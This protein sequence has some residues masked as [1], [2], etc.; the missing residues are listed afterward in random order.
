P[1]GG[2]RHPEQ[3][4]IQI[5][6]TQILFICGGTFTE[7]ADI[8]KRRIGQRAIGFS[9]ETRPPQDPH[10]LAELLEQTTPEDVIE[11]GIIPEFVGRL[12][13][14]TTLAPLDV[15]ALIRIMTEPRNALVRQYQKF[16]EMEGCKLEFQPPAL[17]L[18]AEKALQRNTGARALR[19]I[20]EELM[21]DYMFQLP[22]VGRRTRYVV[23]EAVVQG[24]EDLLRRGRP[25]KESA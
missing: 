14:I 25:L 12:P 23:T 13:I 21:L 6:T 1:Q 4:Y 22:E 18:I 10:E 9:S 20:S 3:Q 17:K 15:P 24:K 2:R 8:I 11:F 5:D 16:F 7:L 19:S